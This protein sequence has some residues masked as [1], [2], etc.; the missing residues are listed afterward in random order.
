MEQS[1]KFSGTLDHWKLDMFVGSGVAVL[2]GSV[3]V[4]LVGEGTM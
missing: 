3:I 1:T 2:V 4:V